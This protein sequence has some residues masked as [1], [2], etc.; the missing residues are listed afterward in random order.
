[1][2]LTVGAG[3]L[4]GKNDARTNY[5]LEGPKHQ[6]L[7]EDYPRRVRALV[8]EHDVLDSFRGKLLFESG[9]GPV[10]YPPIEDFDPD[11]LVASDHT[12]HCPFKGD[13]RYWSPAAWAT[14]RSRTRCGTTPSRSR[15]RRLARGLRSRLPGQAADLWL[16]E[17]EP[18]ARL[19]ARPLP[20]RGRHG[21]LTPGQ[22]AR[23]GGRTVIAECDR[24]KMLFETGLA[25]RPYLL[26][27][28]ML[29]GILAPIETTTLCPYKGEAT[30]WHVRMGDE[31]GRGRRLELRDA[32]AR[33]AA[34]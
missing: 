34:R 11:S 1:M 12:T 23:E 29:P 15:P 16:H 25:P 33:G 14:A 28:D 22:G 20:P 21:E 27:A 10:Y 8:G 2:S 3:P 9:I 26:R 5:S 31:A 4:A 7:W 32:A 19:L 13:A 6:L 17:D 24:P 30:Y 18:R